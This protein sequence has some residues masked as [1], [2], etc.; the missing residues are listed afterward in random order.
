MFEKLK[1]DKSEIE[2]TGGQ[3]KHEALGTNSFKV[4]EIEADDQWSLRSTMQR[5]QIWLPDIEGFFAS[6]GRLLESAGGQRNT[7]SNHSAEFFRRRLRENERT[8]GTDSKNRR[9][10]PKWSLGDLWSKWT[11]YSCGRTFKGLG[12]YQPNENRRHCAEFAAVAVRSVAS[13]CQLNRS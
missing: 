8:L 5:A 1:D 7:A 6:L 9:S 3:V 2:M 13:A 11:F 12:R 10:L 4:A